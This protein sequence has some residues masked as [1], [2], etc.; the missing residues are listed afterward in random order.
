MTANGTKFKH[1]S[2]DADD[3]DE[4]VIQAGAGA[5]GAV[6]NQQNKPEYLEEPAE[7]SADELLAEPAVSSPG[8]SAVSP[9]NSNTA[10]D[11]T[12]A[13]A[14]AAAAKR[15]QASKQTE[16]QIYETETL[17]DL[18]VPPMSA[19]QKGI[20]VFAILML[21]VGVVYYVAFMK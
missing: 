6:Y 12:P 21:V 9:G 13:D 7:A 4:F 2:V 18:E 16:Q 15:G 11:V 3:D 17:E 14:Q 20:I 19:M 1:I 5:T 8:Q 10:A